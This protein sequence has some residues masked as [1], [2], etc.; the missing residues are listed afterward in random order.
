MRSRVLHDM[1]LREQASRAGGLAL[2]RRRLLAQA[3]LLAS[4]I[5][6]ARAAWALD[7]LERPAL[8]V[9]TPERCFMQAAASAGPRLVAVGERGLVLLSDDHGGHWRQALEVPVG[10]T[11]TAVHFADERHGWAVGHAGVILHTQDGGEHW[12]MQADGRRL[13]A[14]AAKAAQEALAGRPQDPAAQRHAKEAQR[15]VDDGPDKPLLDVHFRDARHGWVAGAYGLFFETR[16]GGRSWS[17]AMERLDNPKALHLYALRARAYEVYVVGELG[18][19]HRSS[20]DGRTFAAM[21]SPYQGTWFTVALPAQG[22]RAARRTARQ[23]L[24]LARRWRA[25]AARGR[26]GARDLRGIR[27]A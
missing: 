16:N 21:A 4:G 26:C 7:V 19:L 10:V 1:T 15:L 9:R 11:L 23:C 13:A 8:R 22:G 14:L 12:S 25:M 5:A 20:D 24:L 6:G 18:Q 2:P 17:S 27:G 3:V